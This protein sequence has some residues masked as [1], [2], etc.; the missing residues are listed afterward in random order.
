[1]DME[2][3]KI[4]RF[5]L[6]LR[7]RSEV[8]VPR[9]KGSM[10]RGALGWSLKR[11]AC[12]N[13]DA[14]CGACPV[15]KR[16]PYFVCFETRSLYEGNQRD[17][18]HPFVVNCLDQRSFLKKGDCLDFDLMLFGDFVQVLNYFLYAFMQAGE[19]QGLTRKAVLFDL[20]SVKHEGRNIYD[21]KEQRLLSEFP[22]NPE[23]IH[24][25]TESASV[26]LRFV[27]PTRIKSN[28]RYLGKDLDELGLLKGV[29][30][31]LE[32]LRPY[33]PGLC[34][35]DKGEFFSHAD[36]LKIASKKLKWEQ[37]RRYS[38]RQKTVMALGGVS[39]E[40]QLEGEALKQVLPYFSLMPY[41]NLGKN[42]VFGLG[43]VE[44]ESH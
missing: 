29:Y 13:S 42:R 26:K 17:V 28:K 27:T 37:F 3:I 20:V 41:T 7:P 15:T 22:L 43:Q 9:Q 14:N 21:P 5:R 25:P 18:S 31:T 16:C 34:L 8:V 40:I 6:T 38:N 33:F 1:M 32:G 23:G 44:M 2:S 35:P 24:I 12:V 11:V 39:G 19:R 36:Q 4:Y 10:L 30:H